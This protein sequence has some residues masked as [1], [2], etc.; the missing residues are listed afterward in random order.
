MGLQ[1]GGYGGRAE[2]RVVL[3]KTGLVAGFHF[4]TG[5]FS[6]G[7]GYL[8]VDFRVCRGRSGLLYSHR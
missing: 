4:R 5:S 1:H 2:E 6:K 8:G 7:S 3:G